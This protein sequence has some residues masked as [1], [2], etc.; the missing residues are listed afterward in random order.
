MNAVYIWTVASAETLETFKAVSIDDYDQGK[1]YS[2]GYNTLNTNNDAM[3][4]ISPLPAN[5]SP[6]SLPSRLLSLTASFCAAPASHTGWRL[7]ASLHSHSPQ[8]RYLA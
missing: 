2:S 6:P 5:R 7:K 8:W 4:V 3:R 1:L